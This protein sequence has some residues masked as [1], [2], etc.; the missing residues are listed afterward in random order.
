MSSGRI[1]LDK[2]CENT[3]LC[4]LVM[5]TGA[6]AWALGSCLD[7]SPVDLSG[8]HEKLKP[9]LWGQKDP[10]PCWHPHHWVVTN[11]MFRCPRADI[12]PKSLENCISG[13]VW[14][15]GK[16]LL[17]MQSFLFQGKYNISYWTWVCNSSLL[18][19]C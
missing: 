6:L 3:W 17:H 7:S 14:F 1:K 13:L 5:A 9:A 11:L 2:E 15:L 18:I 10:S 12:V 4:E 19:R 16:Q 8:N